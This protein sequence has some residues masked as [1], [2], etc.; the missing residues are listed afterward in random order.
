MGRASLAGLTFAL[1]TAACAATGEGTERAEAD[2]E[3]ADPA[4]GWRYLANGNYI[5]C[6]IPADVFYAVQKGL[7][8]PVLGFV[9]SG[10][11]SAFYPILEGEAM[12]PSEVPG[13]EGD[14]A[15]LSYRF[16]AFETSRGNKVVNFT[17]LTCHTG[18]INGKAIVGLGDTTVDYTGDLG[19]AARSI[20][21]VTWFIGTDRDVEEVNLFASRFEAVGPHVRTTTVGANPAVNLT[22][23]LM[24]HRDPK[25]LAWSDEPRMALPP[26]E[27]L[28]YD[29]PPW[30]HM[31]RRATAFASGELRFHEGTLMLA[32]LLGTETATDARALDRD[33]RNVEAFIKSVKPPPYPLA[34]DRPLAERGRGVYEKT[35]ASCHGTYGA[36]GAYD[37][38]VVPLDR[39]G[40]DPKAAEQQ[41]LQSTRFYDWIDASP[42]NKA[43]PGSSRMPPKLGYVAPPLDGVW[44]TAP[45]F[46]NGSVPTMEGVLDSSKRP[47]AWTRFGRFATYDTESLSVHFL[48]VPGKH[49]SGIPSKFVYD[50][51]D[52]GYGNGGHTFG[53]ALA[54]DERTAVIEYLKTL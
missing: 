15:N 8:I 21:N 17:C 26:E 54:P 33:F 2:L 52:V 25:T 50:T 18:M 14:N 51:R 31:S 22:Y 4:A 32:S 43:A 20:A 37:E 16:T 29:V 24:A 11:I 39:V 27:S 7:D 49:A 42:Y 44:A 40:T 38:R 5:G 12:Q 1:A 28:P 35:C 19:F 47:T 34:V 10:I 23:A 45:Y 9:G 36:G 30:W 6:G 13:R 41:V 48:P 53:D 3:A 46:H